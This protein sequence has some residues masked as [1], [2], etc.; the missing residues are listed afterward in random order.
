MVYCNLSFIVSKVNP[1]LALSSRLETLLFPN[2]FSSLKKFGLIEK[3]MSNT[4]MQLSHCVQGVITTI[5]I[6]CDWIESVFLIIVFSN[7]WKQ[8]KMQSFQRFSKENYVTL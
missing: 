8:I 3:L 4:R 6:M 5:Y 1:I 2:K 7:L